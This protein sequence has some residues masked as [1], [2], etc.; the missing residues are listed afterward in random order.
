MSH[1]MCAIVFPSVLGPI[2]LVLFISFFFFSSLFFC[3]FFIVESGES[4]CKSFMQEGKFSKTLQQ[5]R[6]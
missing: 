4:T 2:E 1:V 6:K 5:K 3:F